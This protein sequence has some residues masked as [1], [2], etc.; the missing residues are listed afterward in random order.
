MESGG[1][2]EI[3]QQDSKQEN[4]VSSATNQMKKKPVVVAPYVATNPFPVSV[5]CEVCKREK[6]KTPAS[7]ECTTP[8]D[9]KKKRYLCRE[10]R[11]HKEARE[12]MRYLRVEDEPSPVEK[13]RGGAPRRMARPLVEAIKL[14]SKDKKG[15]PPARPALRVLP[16]TH[17][18]VCHLLD[19]WK[20]CAACLAEGKGK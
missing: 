10:H 18:S 17:N 12:A 14:V 1:E 2:R 5:F 3:S 6:V 20:F 9:P 4:P 13:P 16:P 19:N 11:S 7:V 8:G 15:D